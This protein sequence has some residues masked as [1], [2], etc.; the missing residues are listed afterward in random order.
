MEIEE[1]H[2]KTR[3]NGLLLCNS[4]MADLEGKKRQNFQMGSKFA[5]ENSEENSQPIGKLDQSSYQRTKIKHSE[6]YLDAQQRTNQHRAIMA[7]LTVTASQI[8]Y[9]F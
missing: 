1:E 2:H 4:D 6:T 9:M 8:H 5:M 3:R 7:N